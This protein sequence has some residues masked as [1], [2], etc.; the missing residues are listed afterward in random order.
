MP[1]ALGYLAVSFSLGIQAREAGINAWLA[2]LM[3][4]TNLTSAGEFAAIGIIRD[5]GTYLEIA[6]SQIVINLRYMLMSCS[7]SQKYDNN[8]AFGHR[9]GMAGG[10]TDE[11]F[12]IG[13]ATSGRLS[14]YYIYG[15]ML[16]AIPGWSLGTYLGVVLGDVLPKVVVVSLSVALYGMFIAIIVPPA[17][18]DKCVAAAVVIAMLMSYL[19]TKL[20][21]V[22]N[23]GSG[24]TVTLLTVIISLAFAIIHPIKEE[25]A[26]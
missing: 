19:A 23:L 10:I 6:I 1:I 16:V 11:I 2:T 15:A 12:G 14:P 18:K 4:F 9:L 3:S 8:Y 5:G 7:L 20:P 17:K 21:Y 26:A 25:E 22:R 24:V 13:I